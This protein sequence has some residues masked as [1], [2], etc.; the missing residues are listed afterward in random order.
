MVRGSTTRRER[1]WDV[2]IG[3]SSFPSSSTKSKW[4]CKDFKIASPQHRRELERGYGAIEEI[5]LHRSI[6]SPRTWR[7]S[8]DHFPCRRSVVH[9]L[10]WQPNKLRSRAF[11]NSFLKAFPKAFRPKRIGNDTAASRT[12]NLARRFPRVFKEIADNLE[13]SKSCSGVESQHWHCQ[14][15]LGFQVGSSAGSVHRFPG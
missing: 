8:Q 14:P 9:K 3:M 1:A 2:A 10:P 15:F 13:R 12:R 5:T 7:I 11:E 6:P 4:T